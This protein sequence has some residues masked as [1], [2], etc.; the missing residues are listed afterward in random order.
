MPNLLFLTQR[1][2]YPPIKG[3]KIRAWHVLEHLART[4]D[5][6]LG[7]LIDDQADWQHVPFLREVCADAHFARLDRRRAKLLCLR[8]LLTGEP[9]SALFYWDRGLASWVRRVLDEVRPEAI[10]VLSSNMAPYILD[11]RGAERVR[12]V[13]LVD[14]DSAKWRAYAE[15]GRGPMR[16]V[17]AREA[18]VME[19]LERRIARECDWST[20]V[21]E[22]EAA[23][24]KR[25]APESGAKVRAISNG[26]DAAFFDPALSFERP[27]PPGGPVF[28]FTGAM[29]YPPNVDAAIWF[30]DA[31][32]PL[33]DGARFVIVGASPAPQV[34][35][36]S[37]RA[38]ITVTGRVPDVRPYLAHA[39]AAVAPMR[40]ARGIQNKVLEAMA[41]ARPVVVTPDA[42]EGIAA[43]AGSEVLVANGAEAF[44]AAC[45]TAAGPEGAAIGDAARARVVADYVWSKRLRAFDALLAPAGTVERAA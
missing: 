17:H 19:A 34:Q 40:I 9:L 35:A 21:S 26:V 31:V 2:P 5:V 44:A 16:R 8:G 30:A 45:R 28:V 25:I 18:R 39:D 23:L 4:H 42:L 15:T 36:L 32:L 33:L 24:F 41:M 10:F 7:C 12:V 37:R 1:I 14:V 6:H 3:E 20:F 38:G 43:A 27:F 13:D 11:R 29:D 22:E